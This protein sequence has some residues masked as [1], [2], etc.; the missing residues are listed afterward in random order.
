M[1]CHGR[2]RVGDRTV[3]VIDH[4]AHPFDL[5]RGVFEPTRLAIDLADMEGGRPE[6]PVQPDTVWRGLLTSL[7]ADRLGV[8]VERLDDARASAAEDYPGYVRGLFADAGIDAMIM[9]AAWPPDSEQHV[10][11]FASL[12]GCRVHLL[13]RLDPYVD[14]LLDEGVPAPGIVE[15]IDDAIAA[16]SDRGYCGFK[17]VLAY[18]SGLAVDPT[19]TV[20]AA[21]AALRAGGPRAAKPLRDLLFGRL[22]DHAAETGLPVQVHTGFGDSD[23]RLGRADPLLLED[24]LDTPG[25]R[26]ALVVLL[27]SAFPFQDQAAYLAAARRNVHIDLSLVN[28]FAPANLADGIRRVVGLAPV[29]RVVFGTDAHVLPEAFWFAATQLQEAWQQ[30]R[31]GLRQQGMHSDWLDR[32]E[33]AMFEGNARRLYGLGDPA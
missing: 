13:W 19:V 26:R 6:A 12:S 32:A 5:E 28:L 31:D 25:G 9:D 21:A 24:V 1:L 4:H 15:R 23:L 11:Q 10:E 18:R 3:V 14:E 2:L 16:A 20:G 33:D 22:L 30:V 8:A 27:H 17:T 7:L 29:D